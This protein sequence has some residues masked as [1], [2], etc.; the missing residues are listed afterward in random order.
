MNERSDSKTTGTKDGHRILLL[1]GDKLYAFPDQA[2]AQSWLDAP[3]AV[4]GNVQMFSVW[5]VPLGNAEVAHECGTRLPSIEE[6]TE[7]SRRSGS[8]RTA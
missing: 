3:H 1:A 7:H 4:S 8:A 5:N 2:T 6:A